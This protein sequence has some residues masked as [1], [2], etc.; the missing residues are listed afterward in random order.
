MVIIISTISILGVLFFIITYPFKFRLKRKLRRVLGFP[1]ITHIK[2]QDTDF[3]KYTEEAIEKKLLIQ[4]HR[5]K[6]SKYIKENLNYTIITN[7]NIEKDD[8]PCLILLHGLR[9]SSEDWLEKAKICEN[10]L[11]LLESGKIKPLNIILLDSGYQGTSWYTNFYHNSECSYEDY[12]VKELLPI[13]REKFPKSKFSIAG[14]SMGGYGAFKLG[15]KHPDIFHVI[16]SFSGAISIVRMSVN[17]RV[18]RIFNFLYIPKWLFASEDK[19][20]FLRVFSSWGHKILQEDPYTL[21]K[22]LD[23]KKFKDR[24]FYAS[25]G[26]ND[27]ESHLMLQQWTD[28]IGRMKKHGYDFIGYLCRDEV[29]TWDFVSRDLKNF[30]VYFNDKIN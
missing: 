8:I 11:T 7:K 12:I 6:N 1:Q 22:K 20:Q 21:I 23:K 28:T 3:S 29:H 16:G 24:Y 26:E 13:F 17:R 27:V 25:V 10:Y 2:N 19:L 18:I 15:L 5:F 4:T 9:D 14:F 30:L